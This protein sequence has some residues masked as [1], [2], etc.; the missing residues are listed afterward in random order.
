MA[1]EKYLLFNVDK[2]QFSLAFSDI[3]QIIAAEEPSPLPDFPDYILGT[4]AYEGSVIPIISLRRRFHFEDAPLSDRW[5]I[6]ITENENK[7]VGLLCDSVSSFTELSDQEIMPA[8]QLNEEAA[9]RFLKGELI[10]DGEHILLLDPVK[11]IKLKDAEVFGVC[12]DIEKES[13][14]GKEEVSE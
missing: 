9:A 13:D 4:I 12:E 2:R 1:V 10:I 11:I 3:L 14:E 7:R 5:C 8:A 6:I